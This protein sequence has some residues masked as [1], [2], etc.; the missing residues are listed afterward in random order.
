VINNN[1][2]SKY[3]I[4]E[5]SKTVRDLYARRCRLEE[6]EMTCAAQAADLLTPY[7]A[8]GDSLLDVGCGSGYFFHSLRK[9]GLQVEYYGIDAAPSLIEMGQ[10]YMPAY[11]LPPENL[12]VMRIEDLDGDADHVICMNVL[13]NIDNYHQPL[14]RILNVARKTVILRESC[15][16]EGSY[17][18]VKDE[19]LDKE[20]ELKVYVNAYP[21]KEFMDFIT[22]YGFKVDLITDRRTGGKT[23]MIIGYPHHW[24][25]FIARKVTS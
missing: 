4:W 7:V 5:H 12:H 1:G 14:E 25:F 10:K 20:N 13:S 16:E 21:L 17:L 11:G 22:S 23:E 24:K 18:Y 3:C 9:R 2:W 19:Y 6:E 15:K 8:P